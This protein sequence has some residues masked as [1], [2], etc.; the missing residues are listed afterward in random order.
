MRSLTLADVEPALRAAWS[1]ETCDD[2]D[3]ADW[4]PAH[5]ARGQCGASALVLHDLLG[6]ELLL[7]EVLLSDGSRQGWHWWNR[8]PGGAE[9]DLTGEQF[10]STEV[11]QRPRVIQRPP[12]PPRRCAAQYLRLRATGY[13]AL[14]IDG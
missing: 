1:L 12:G 6:G 3:L 14:G 9:V 11:V 2:A 10:G 13:E 8:L 5:P 4:S 7:A